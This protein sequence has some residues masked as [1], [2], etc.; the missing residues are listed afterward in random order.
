MSKYAEP[1][2]KTTEYKSI[3]EYHNSGMKAVSV[4]G[5]IDSA[6]AH[7]VASFLNDTGENMLYVLP[8]DTEAKKMADDL[9]FFLGENVEVLFFPKKD[10]VFYNVEAMNSDVLYD[11]I[12]ALHTLVSSEKPVIIVSSAE[13]AIQYT[14]PMELMTHIEFCEGAVFDIA[15]L[16]DALMLMGYLRSDNVE[17]VGQFSLRG[18]ILDIFS[19][20]EMYPVRI[21]F[22][23]NEVDTVRSFD[24]ATQISV[25]RLKSAVALCCRELMYTK[26]AMAAFTK[27]LKAAA[28]ENENIAADIERFNTRYY[29]SAAD[30]Y[31]PYIYNK[32][33]T[34]AHY[35]NQGIVVL[36]NPPLI[37]DKI[38]LARE[39]MAENVLSLADKGLLVCPNKAEYVESSR[40]LFEREGFTV[41]IS[42]ISSHNHLVKA[43]ASVGFTMRP[44]QSYMGKAELILEDIE[45]WHR[46]K[47]AINIVAGN[48]KSTEGFVKMLED[49]GYFPV[50]TSKSRAA[51]HGEI[52]ITTGSITRGFEYPL[53]KY[54]LVGEKELFGGERTHTKVR[55]MAGTRIK[56]YNDL[57]V[58]DYVVHHIHGIGRYLGIHRME[59]DGI[60][61]DYLKLMYRDNDVLY[62]PATAL[63]LINKYVAAETGNVK[64]NKMGGA[65]FA[66]VKSRVR[67]S[68]QEMA[69]KLVKLYAARLECKGHAFAKDNDWQKNF[70]EG[71][72]FVETEDQIRCISEVK[73][74]MESVRPMDRLLCGDVGFGKTEVALRAAFKAV[75]D[76]KQVAYLVP[77][78]VLA[79]QHFNTFMSRMAEY[80]ITVEM[81]CRFRTPKQQKEIAK[82]IKEGTVDIVIGTHRILQKDV[83][84]K[85]LGLLIIDEEQRFGV[86]DKEK[87]KELKTAVDVLTLSATPIPR[88]MHMAMIGI[89][90]MSVLNEPPSNRY[91]VQTYVMEYDREVVREAILKELDRGGQVYYVFNRVEGIER[92]AAEIQTM[93]PDA[94]VA[95]AHGQM[96]EKQLEDIMISAM[97]GEIDILVCT[98][99]IETGLDIPNINTIII[100]NADCMGLSQ[101][102]QLRGRVGRSTRRAYAY[103]TYRKN[104]EIN[105]TADKRLKSIRD[106]TEF[107]SGFKIALRDL[108]IRGAGNV[109]GPEQHGVMDAVGYD[110]YCKILGE[111]VMAAKG[112]TVKEEIV[113]SIDIKTDAFIPD[114]YIESGN[115]RIEMYKR[116]SSVESEEDLQEML[117]ELIDRFGEPPESVANL[118]NI[119]L[120]GKMAAKCGITEI[121]QQGEFLRFRILDTDEEKAIVVKLC[122]KNKQRLMFINDK[123]PHILMRIT[124]K[125]TAALFSNIKIVLQAYKELQNASE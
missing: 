59:V 101:L 58:G 77:T 62:I 86:G 47:Y 18:G 106:F 97:E 82:K 29:F 124:E 68:A 26:E 42:G 115:T 88:T 81:M 74:D 35:F 117:E 36:D 113:T 125:N 123:K 21:E 53:S 1:L 54:V 12:S 19:P 70:E 92:I 89:R 60:I 28:A 45:Y 80:P 3:L 65:E 71:F 27:K 22:F 114:K 73:L 40:L 50:V 95:V 76:G 56:S 64:L 10:Y 9:R 87:I 67:K 14:V 17:G 57:E 120:I 46:E 78:T 99:I 109:L 32:I 23:D 44:M 52:V 93:A 38:K 6:K 85:D 37:N 119:A 31:L 84:F 11:R 98:T 43:N 7:F 116:I 66:K 83:S 24:P 55:K 39:E 15:E 33:T 96:S 90:D 79:R 94:V 102:Y 30:K 49:N 91:P 20:G 112:E 51:E 103:L 63:H 34:L 72:P 118:L 100:E 61:K 104:K 25:S 2:V 122:S 105:E 75:M 41:A 111:A 108:E 4:T 110:L 5:L 16:T 48:K 107:G 13:A 69:D 8:S 121:I